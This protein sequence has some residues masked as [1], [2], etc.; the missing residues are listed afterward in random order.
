MKVEQLIA[1]R[2]GS[3]AYFMS[4]A[5][6][7]EDYDQC[8]LDILY[9]QGSS[10]SFQVVIEFSHDKSNWFRKTKQNVGVTYAA[11]EDL[12]LYSTEDGNK[13]YEFPIAHKWMRIGMLVNGTVTGSQIAAACILEE[14]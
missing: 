14:A 8:V 7:V 12:I 1:A 11:L 13:S 4:K 3:N 2:T 5:L 9:T 6:S 10:T